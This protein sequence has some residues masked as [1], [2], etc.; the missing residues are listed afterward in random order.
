MKKLLSTFSLVL[1]LTLLL[2]GCVDTTS[3]TENESVTPPSDA[4]PAEA[5]DLKDAEDSDAVLD[6]AAAEPLAV[7][8]TNLLNGVTV[9]VAPVVI[10]GVANGDA[11][12]VAVNGWQLTQFKVGDTT[13]SYIAKPEFKNL[14]V[15]ENVY[16]IIARDAA[17]QEASTTLTFDFQPANENE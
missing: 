8:V 10:T 13:W 12:A 1:V 6:S 7:A 2:A 9:T 3:E 4:V 15:G 14:V 5:V 11:V 16:E 17:G